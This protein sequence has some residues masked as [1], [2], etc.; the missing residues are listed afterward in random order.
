MVHRQHPRVYSEYHS[1]SYVCI[2]SRPY[3]DISAVQTHHN[4]HVTLF[5]MDPA[6]GTRR[7]CRRPTCLGFNDVAPSD[8]AAND[9]ADE[10]AND[11][12][13]EAAD[14]A[15]GV[16]NG[17]VNN[18]EVLTAPDSGAVQGNLPNSNVSNG[19]A[20]AAP[21][22]GDLHGDNIR[23]DENAVPLLA[24]KAKKQCNQYSQAV[25][26]ILQA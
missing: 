18:G 13:N 22:S 10:A 7:V 20:D 19:E 23:L 12:S 4:V 8:K 3:Q 15:P 11:A 21:L 9:T 5:I 26:K 2:T 25:K 16:P 17:D 6:R 24:P 14:Q 1:Y